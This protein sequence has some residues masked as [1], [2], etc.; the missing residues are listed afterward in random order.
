MR[1]KPPAGLARLSRCLLGTLAFGAA[2]LPVVAQV[3]YVRQGPTPVGMTTSI[4]FTQAPLQPPN[5]LHS[6]PA[7]A[8][9]QLVTFD[10]TYDYDGNGNISPVRP[11]PVDFSLDRESRATFFGRGTE[12]PTIYFYSSPLLRLFGYERDDDLITSTAPLDFIQGG[13]SS[14]SV[15]AM[16]VVTMIAD[17]HGYL[18]NELTG[19]GTAIFDANGGGSG[20]GEFINARYQ[21]YAPNGL[22]YVLDYGNDR[23]QMLNPANFFAPVGA[24]NLQ[25]G[26]TTA[27]MQF[28]IGL[29]G[30][31][32]LG[33]G[34]GGGSVYAADGAYLSSFSA[35]GSTPGNF[36]MNPYVTADPEGNVFVF[37]ST[38]AHQYVDASVVP[39]PSACALATGTLLG[40]LIISAFNRKATAAKARSLSGKRW[41]RAANRRQRRA[42]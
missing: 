15:S 25:T 19:A 31:V 30:N 9:S 29:N 34:L 17:D 32:Y 1:F 11:I 36:G 14:L 42:A 35:P 10:T 23:L 22:L 12:H 7:E 38:G 26:V 37:D 41:S 33:D 5:P 13:V 40:A 28:A 3:S 4:A 27:N 24:F 6:S 18:V 39:E 16:G 8:G 20:P 21:I 2:C